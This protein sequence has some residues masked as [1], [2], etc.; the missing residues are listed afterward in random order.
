MALTD[1][2]MSQ[3]CDV[4]LQLI[5]EKGFKSTTMDLVASRLHISKRTLYEI[6][7]SKTGM[8]SAVLEYVA[9]REK[10]MYSDIVDNAPDILTAIIKILSLQRERIAAV[11]V[12]FFKDMDRLYSIVRPKY[13]MRRDERE[14]AMVEVFS[15]GI[16]EGY[17]R[18]DV[19]YQ[20]LARMQE[21]QME[22]LK[23]MEDIFPKDISLLEVYDSISTTYLRGIL[24]QKGLDK[25]NEIQNNKQ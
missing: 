16:E 6:F 25:F 11:N 9:L 7:E 3:L 24:T 22:S 8:L 5:M 1:E 17:F 4:I 21:I 18:S 19:N 20:V 23:R 10:K 14:K 12:N 15:R 2:Q 13:D